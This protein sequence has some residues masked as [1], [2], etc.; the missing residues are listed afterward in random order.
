VSGTRAGDRRTEVDRLHERADHLEGDPA[1]RQELA[2]APAVA[3]D[4]GAWGR[5]ERHRRRPDAAIS[6]RAGIFARALAG[7][8]GRPGPGGASETWDACRL[9]QMGRG[10]AR[11]ETRSDP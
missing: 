7:P 5:G 10:A 8:C 4:R 6:R 11:P 1:A 3:G 9:E 2:A